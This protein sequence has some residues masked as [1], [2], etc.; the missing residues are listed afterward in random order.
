MDSSFANA[1]NFVWSET[2]AGF[3]G[4]YQTARQ[5]TDVMKSVPES[6]LMGFNCA[7]IRLPDNLSKVQQVA[8]PSQL[9][10]FLSY[11]CIDGK[12]FGFRNYKIGSGKL[13]EK[14]SQ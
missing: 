10:Q 6:L 11:E 12:M 2:N 14:V 4:D 7:C 3:D 13:L 8:S 5:L 1:K 9:N